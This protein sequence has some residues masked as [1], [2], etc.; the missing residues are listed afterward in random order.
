MGSVCRCHWLGQQLLGGPP[1]GGGASDS[2]QA[3]LLPLRRCV[4]AVL[5]D[6]LLNAVLCAALQ[7]RGTASGIFM[8]P[9]LIGPVRFQSRPGPHP[10]LAVACMHASVHTLWGNPPSAAATCKHVGGR[11]SPL[12]S[13]LSLPASMHAS[14][15]HSHHQWL[16][17]PSPVDGSRTH[18]ML[19]YAMLCRAML[20]HAV[21]CH[22]MPYVTMPFM[23]AL[24]TAR[25]AYGPRALH[26]IIITT[27]DSQG[28]SPS[29]APSPSMHACIALHRD[30]LPFMQAPRRSSCTPCMHGS[31]P[32]TVLHRIELCIAAH[33]MHATAASSP[34]QAAAG[35]A[36]LKATLARKS[37]ATAVT[38]TEQGQLASR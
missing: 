33:R 14:V 18:A 19:R 15:V 24:L 30:A 38:A 21:S 1:G 26:G 25:G 3:A 7:V 28:A 17:Q 8:I 37:E 23:C 32:H 29:S 35:A 22:P 11:A 31:A 6:M 2:K 36:G 16:G 34:Q 10:S 4:R 9:M 5:P 20:C 12:H 27:I 13:F